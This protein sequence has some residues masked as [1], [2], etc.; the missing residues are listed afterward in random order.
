MRELRNGDRVNVYPPDVDAR[1]APMS[2]AVEGVMLA[3]GPAFSLV[4]FVV[5][6]VDSVTIVR[7]SRIRRIFDAAAEAREFAND[8]QPA[9]AKLNTTIA[10]ASDRLDRATT[11]A[12]ADQAIA[13]I[14]SLLPELLAVIMML[15]KLPPELLPVVERIA[16]KVAQLAGGVDVV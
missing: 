3:T 14:R 12:E 15:G 10:L 11:S 9:I 6:G 4:G 7:S 2:T 13:L 16:D 5:D 8:W 1:T